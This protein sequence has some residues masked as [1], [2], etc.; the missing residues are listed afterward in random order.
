MPL[1]NALFANPQLFQAMQNDPRLA[2][3]QGLMQQGSSTAPVRSPLEGLARALQGGLG[4]FQAGR[5]RKGYEAQDDRYRAGLAEALKGGDVIGALSKSDDPF[6]QQTGLQAQLQR[7]MKDPTE[8]FTTLTD[9]EEQ[10]L[11]LP[12]AGTYQ[13]GSLSGKVD[14][15]SKP[16]EGFK[17]GDTRK[18]KKGD[19]EI[20]EQFTEGGWTQLSDGQ[21]FASPASTT[22]NVG[23]SGIDYGDPEPGLA[24]KRNPDGTVALDERG[25]PIALPYQ[26]GKPYAELQKVTEAKATKEGQ[27][28]QAADIVT[29][30][31][32]RALAL[33]DSAIIPTTGI[34]G[35]FV[36]DI[37]GT[38]ANDTRALLDTIKANVGFDK[39]Q[40][41]RASS[42]TGGA[43]GS[44]TEGELKLLSSVLG[45]LEQSQSKDQFKA[46]LS[47]LKE[48]YLDVIHGPGNRPDSAPTGAAQPGQMPE[49]SDP[50]DPKLK[51]LPKGSAFYAIG[52]DGKKTLRYVP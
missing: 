35:N 11:G 47:R 39:L 17:I 6:L 8:S 34:V 49:F 9:A 3:A 20:T 37:G 27:Q 24:W 2:M 7:A 10:A 28:Q 12:T 32:D 52:P 30:D 13:R 31:I 22:V 50:N 48:I 16:P 44:I 19:R 25:A 29:Q 36:K 45:N 1:N 5:V 33:A 43:L 38:A 41:M 4:G 40:Q 21:A 46:N 26:G 18:Y 42:L 15:L 51:A 14:V 23:P